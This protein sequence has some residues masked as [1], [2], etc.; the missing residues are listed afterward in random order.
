MTIP[1]E[2]CVTRED[3]LLAMLN[4]SNLERRLQSFPAKEGSSCSIDLSRPPIAIQGRW[5]V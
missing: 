1:S 3:D 5:M 2:A 4:Y